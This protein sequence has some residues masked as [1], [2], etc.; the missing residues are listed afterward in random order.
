MRAKQAGVGCTDNGAGACR[1]TVRAGRY[2]HSFTR[3]TSAL[4]SDRAVAAAGGAERCFT[5]RA[6]ALRA[7]Q[8]SPKPATKSATASNARDVARIVYSARRA[9]HMRIYPSS[10]LLHGRSVRARGCRPPEQRWREAKDLQRDSHAVVVGS[11]VGRSIAHWA[12]NLTRVWVLTSPQ[13]PPTHHHAAAT[14]TPFL[15]NRLK[16]DGHQSQILLARI[17]LSAEEV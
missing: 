11:M 4:S 10:R 8:C 6:R 15:T 13:L 3:E 14:R 16:N 5:F 12:L 9:S 1:W 7:W 2:A 17:D